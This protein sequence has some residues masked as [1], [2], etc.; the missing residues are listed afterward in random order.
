MTNLA[1]HIQMNSEEFISHPNDFNCLYDLD[2]PH[3]S[4][5]KALLKL[6][7]NVK[8]EYF[9]KKLISHKI[10]ETLTHDV[11]KFLEFPI[12]PIGV[13]MGPSRVGKSTLLKKIEEE[14][15]KQGTEQ[16]EIDR[17]Y[18]PIVSIVAPICHKSKYW[19]PDVYQLGYEAINPD[20]SPHCHGSYSPKMGFINALKYRKLLAFQIDEAHNFTYVRNR[21]IQSEEI[22][23]WTNEVPDCVFLLYGT[24]HLIPLLNLTAQLSFRAKEF[25]FPR[26]VPCQKSSSEY[27]DFSGVLRTFEVFL[28]IENPPPLVEHQA[29]IYERTLGC[30]GV[31]KSW[32]LDTLQSAYE[33]NLSSI[34]WD[35][36]IKH[37]P[38]TLKLTVQLREISEGEEYIRKVNNEDGFSI[39]NPNKPQDTNIPIKNFYDQV[40]N[41]KRLTGR[42]RKF[43]RRKPVRIKFK[44]E[45]N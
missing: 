34:T 35:M 7:S 39:N 27:Q 22:K 25:H 5:P 40:T 1:E 43:F 16:M 44:T 32:L 26:Y 6:P 30:I 42:S 21:L 8:L 4:F 33:E 2:E 24:Y 18:L 15:I 45:T 19:W 9:K 29:E 28:P 3:S 14:V 38:S 20:L 37:S 17:S 41:H 10:I 31:L 23:S 12:S 11:L 13:I 36:L